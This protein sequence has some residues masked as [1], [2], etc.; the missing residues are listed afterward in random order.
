MAGFVVWR[1]GVG[2]GA[3]AAAASCV[4]SGVS[5]YSQVPSVARHLHVTMVASAAAAAGRSASSISQQEMVIDRQKTAAVLNPK[6]APPEKVVPLDKIGNQKK[7][8]SSSSSKFLLLGKS[9]EELQDLAAAHGERKY[10][11]R[12]LHQLIYKNKAKEIQDCAQLPKLFRDSLETAGWSI[13]R[14]PIHHVATSSDGT[15]KILLQLVDDRL[16]ET[17]GIPV[18]ETPGANRL[19]ACVSSQVGCPLKCTFCATGKGGFFR[20]LKPHEI[21]EQV[22]AIE[23]MFNHRVTNVV[24]MGM[25]EPML[26][27]TNVLAALRVLNQDLHIGQRMMTISTVGVPNTIARLATH[28]LQSTLAISLHAPN[29]LLRSQIVPSAKTYP[30][31]ALM[32]DCSHYFKTTGRRLSFEYTLLEGINDQKHHAEEL[33]DLLHHWELGRHVNIIPYNPVADSEFRRPRKQAILEFVET[34]AARRVTASVR[35]TRG[36]DAN[37]ACGQLRNEFQKVPIRVPSGPSA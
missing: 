26:N 12:Q 28:K 19:T 13:G 1:R 4:R 33:A 5:A 7:R 9:E 25:G 2:G 36:L 24:F 32:E 10:R 6:E 23:E 16:V 31:E 18:E 29:Q 34:L 37:A 27:L 30:L 15:A 20:S 11:G 17:V 21:V 3:A 8:S 14:A 22:L 35:Q